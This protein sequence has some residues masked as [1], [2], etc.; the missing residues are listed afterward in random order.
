MTSLQRTK[1]WEFYFLKQWILGFCEA[2]FGNFNL[3]TLLVIER[4]TSSNMLQNT[5]HNMVQ[6]S[7]SQCAFNISC[8][9][10]LSIICSRPL[11]SNLKCPYAMGLWFL[12]F[13]SCI[14]VYDFCSFKPQKD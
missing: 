8:H 6:I 9:V 14:V 4:P 11:S 7:P 2:P 5:M 10:K 13:L 1:P 12:K 3:A